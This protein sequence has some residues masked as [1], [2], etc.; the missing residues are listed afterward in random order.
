MNKMRKK[1]CSS[2]DHLHHSF[3]TGFSLAFSVGWFVVEEM[4]QALP[5]I[6]I[7]GLAG[8]RRES[9]RQLVQPLIYVFQA[10]EK[11]RKEIVQWF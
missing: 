7:P 2:N 1:P 10:Q 8:G 5:G 4:S 3:L 9:L 11:L 6:N